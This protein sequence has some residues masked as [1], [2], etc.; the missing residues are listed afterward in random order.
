MTQVAHS[1]TVRSCGQWSNEKFLDIFKVFSLGSLHFPMLN[2]IYDC[3]GQWSNLF[4]YTPV[5][6]KLCEHYNSD[7]CIF[8]Y[9]FHTY[10][11]VCAMCMLRRYWYTVKHIQ[12]KNEINQ[13]EINSILKTNLFEYW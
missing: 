12:I 6:V 11:I 2:V 9:I 13:D 7:I 5:G 1:S 3:L 8:V 10:I 4:E